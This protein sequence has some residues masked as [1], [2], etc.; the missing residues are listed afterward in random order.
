MQ[1]LH[2]GFT[3]DKGANTINVHWYKRK[4]VLHHVSFPLHITIFHIENVFTLILQ[5][6]DTNIIETAE[7][8]FYE[9][10]VDELVDA[11]EKNITV[12]NLILHLIRIGPFMWMSCSCGDICSSS[13]ETMQTVWS[14]QAK[15]W[16]ACSKTSCPDV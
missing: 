11:L 2:V 12:R 8:R 7:E 1:P 5:V 16:E 14:D 10:A 6:W 13:L 4:A 15:A 3:S 9:S